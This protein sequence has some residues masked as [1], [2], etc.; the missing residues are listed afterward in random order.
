MSNNSVLEVKNLTKFYKQR[1]SNKLFSKKENIEAV[2]GVSFHVNE[3]EIFGIIG[4]SGCGKSTLGRVI[5]RLEEP[6]SGEILFRRKDSKIILKNNAKEY[7]R[8]IQMVF[9]NPFDSFLPT[10]TIREILMRPLIIHNIGKDESERNNLIIKTL[11][12]GGLSPAKDYLDRYPHELSGGQ[13]QRISILRSMIVDPA[14]IVTDEPVSM[15]DVSVRADI[16][17]L[18]QKLTKEY[19]TAVMFI[20]HDIA[21]IRYIADRC[22]V[23]YLGKIVEMGKT[24]DIIANPKHPYTQA[25][26]TNTASI[27]IDHPV[28]KIPIKGEAPSPIHPG[29]GCYFAP[30]CY[31]ACER[32]FKEYPEIK[33]LKDG[34][35]VSCHLVK[36]G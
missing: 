30:R 25:L 31:C 11:E 3:G 2:G 5:V 32:C 7:H 8:L 27:D 24:D 18:L 17:G 28:K 13:L 22:A 15:L 36:E 21:V 23:M 35:S 6:T 12:D 29:P 14:F 19:K 4:E 26:I 34:R 9:Q 33:Q 20:S 1:G 10:E 16:I